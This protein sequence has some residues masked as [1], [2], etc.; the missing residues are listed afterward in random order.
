MTDKA[1]ETP[2]ERD[3]KPLRMTKR[4]GQTTY[5]VTI[6]FSKTSRETL[7]DKML[8]LILREVE[9]AERES[10]PPPKT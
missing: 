9:N 1:R 5:K 7:H 4:I 6:H 3:M 8:R 10:L 2:Q